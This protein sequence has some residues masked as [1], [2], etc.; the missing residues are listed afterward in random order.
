MLKNYEHQNKIIS[1]S[2]L[3]HL[4][5]P[6]S[7]PP[8]PIVEQIKHQKEYEKMVNDLKKKGIFECKKI[9]IQLR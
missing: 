1:S 3:I 5:R 8:K 4:Q 9:C 7:L 2:H 6:E